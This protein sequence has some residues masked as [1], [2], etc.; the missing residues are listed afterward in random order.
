MDTE[1]DGGEMDSS[2]IEF[3]LKRRVE[4]CTSNLAKV[5]MKVNP[6]FGQGQ[7]KSGQVTDWMNEVKL[8]I[9]RFGS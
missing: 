3:V 1:L 5:K 7:T 2:A 6:W 4:W 8:H 9:S